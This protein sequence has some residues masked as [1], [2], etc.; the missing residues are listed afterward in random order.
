MFVRVGGLGWVAIVVASLAGCGDGDAND[1]GPGLD[2]DRTWASL[3]EGER[4]DLC[5]F[6]SGMLGGY[7]F[8]ADCPDHDAAAWAAPDQATCVTSV[9][10]TCGTPVWVME[11]CIEAVSKDLCHGRS[12]QATHPACVRNVQCR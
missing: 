8:Q 4:A 3:S 2:A 11:E 5:D 9:P 12:I 10:D 6:L 7:G 1:A